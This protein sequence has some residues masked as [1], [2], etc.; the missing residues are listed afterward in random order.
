MKITAW[1][2]AGKNTNR[3]EAKSIFLKNWYASMRGVREKV[4]M[5]QSSIY[6]LFRTA[7]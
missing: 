7:A 4:A 2:D 5:R 1:D 3:I 6:Q